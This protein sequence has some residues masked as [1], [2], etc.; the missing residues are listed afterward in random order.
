MWEGAINWPLSNLI[1]LKIHMKTSTGLNIQQMLK[2]LQFMAL[3]MTK[4]F[5]LPYLI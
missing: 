1:E 3:E 2:T 4:T 5:S